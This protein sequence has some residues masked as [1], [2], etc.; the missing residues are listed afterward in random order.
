MLI[1]YKI[2][3]NYRAYTYKVLSEL[4]VV[5]IILINIGFEFIKYF[6]Y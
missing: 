1:A 5:V 2:L 3:L 6:S 4:N